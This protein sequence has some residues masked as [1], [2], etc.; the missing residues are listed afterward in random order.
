MVGLHTA[1]LGVEKISF[2][3]RLNVKGEAHGGLWTFTSCFSV[4]E[5]LGVGRAGVN[6]TH[7]KCK[8]EHHK[9]LPV[10]PV[11]VTVR[12]SPL[13]GSGELI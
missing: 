3:C 1:V 11:W 13:C 4:A 9:C 2:S 12:V 7:G 8:V 10:L 5:H 6:F